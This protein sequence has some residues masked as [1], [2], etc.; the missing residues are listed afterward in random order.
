MLKVYE[1]ETL[2]K[3]DSRGEP[4]LWRAMVFEYPDYAEIVC[5]YGKLSGKLQKSHDR[6][7]EGKNLGKANATTYVQQAIAEAEA[8]W[9]KQME[10]KG[11]VDDLQLINKDQRAG[12]EPMLAHRFDKYP[13][14]ITFPCYIQPKLDGHRCIAVIEGGQASL[15]SR[16]RKPITGL[17]HVVAALE[18]LGLD[19]A[20]FDGELYNHDYHD[21]FEELTGFIRSE[22]PKDGCEVVQYHIYDL[23]DAKAHYIDRL[24]DLTQVLKR[25]RGYVE[26]A[27]L[28]PVVTE[29]VQ[30]DEVNDLF[31]E[32]RAEGYEGAILR[33]TKGKYEGKRSYNLQKVKSFVD[34]EFDIVGVEEGRGKMEGCA[35]FVCATAEGKTFN[36]KM[37]GSL[38]HL[39]ELYAR[40]DTLLGKKVTV[41]YQEFTKDGIPRFPV[42]LRLHE[43]L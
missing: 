20:I 21:R 10:R 1:S 11:Y 6:V 36:A 43:A 22:N 12:A 24:G 42:A 29:F 37:K 3:A 34:A 28:R 41:Q 31:N 26:G 15:F 27:V 35:I 16:Q 4:M 2:Y 39:A 32:F 5:E 18:S 8:K 33:N 38:D 9:T 25:A 40:K 19:D 13:H 14:K 17:P 7:T 23:V 30:E